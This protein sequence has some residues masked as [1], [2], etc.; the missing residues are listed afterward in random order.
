VAVPLQHVCVQVGSGCLYVV[1]LGLLVGCPK[2]LLPWVLCGRGSAVE[3]GAGTSLVPSTLPSSCDLFFK[4]CFI[5]WP[6]WCRKGLRSH[7]GELLLMQH[8]VLGLVD[9]KDPEKILKK[10]K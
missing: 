1:A 10:E 5:A 4:A 6:A 2:R 9:V 8:I 7:L 3:F